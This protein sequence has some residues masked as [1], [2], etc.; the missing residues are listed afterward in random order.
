M[1]SDVIEVNVE[2]VAK[3]AA[4]VP[5][6]DPEYEKLNSAF[7]AACLEREQTKWKLDDKNFE[8]A[9]LNPSEKKKAKELKKEIK[10][11][12]KQLK[13]AQKKEDAAK[14]ARDKYKA[15][16]AENNKKAVDNA[17]AAEVSTVLDEEGKTLEELAAMSIAAQT[18]AKS[19]SSSF[20]GMCRSC[21]RHHQRHEHV[22]ER[23]LS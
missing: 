16:H 21:K 22:F 3:A 12:E 5:P 18:S 8:L 2:V 9:K 10:A 7:V 11:L 1:Q 14:K 4:K 17:F 19:E 13:A 23:L 15:K 6:V 20:K